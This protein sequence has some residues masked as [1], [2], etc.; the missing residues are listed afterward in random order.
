MNQAECESFSQKLREQSNY[1]QE[2]RQSLEEKEQRL[3]IQIN[4]FENNRR[5]MEEKI[6]KANNIFSVRENTIKK[7]EKLVTAREIE[8]SRAE[9][10]RSTELLIEMTTNASSE[11]KAIAKSL[12]MEIH[13]LRTKL[14][15]NEKMLFELNEKF[16]E[17]NNGEKLNFFP[18]F[19][20]IE[21]SPHVR[22]AHFSPRDSQLTKGEGDLVIRSPPA[23]ERT[24]ISQL[25]ILNTEDHAE[26]GETGFVTPPPSIKRRLFTS[27]PT[28]SEDSC[29]SWN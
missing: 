19:E 8:V 16:K 12:F 2:V 7:L 10:I 11:T 25:N 22:K 3:N 15:E 24:K 21:K 4:V 6:A 9:E 1:L 20:S 5:I 28:F 26:T 29:I 17:M 23:I 18:K 13:S 14:K 27:S